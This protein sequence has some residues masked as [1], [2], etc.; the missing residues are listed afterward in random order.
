MMVGYVHGSTTTWQVWDPQHQTV[1]TQSD[2]IFNEARNMYASLPGGPEA[3]TDSLGLI[4]EL[5]HVEVLAAQE[6]GRTATVQKVGRTATVQEVGRTATAQEVGRIAAV[7]EVGRTAA[8]LREVGRTA[9][10]QEVGRTAA[11]L[12]EV[13]CMAAREAD[14]VYVA[15]R[16]AIREVDW[17]VAGGQPRIQAEVAPD[18][19]VGT[20]AA[21]GKQPRERVASLNAVKLVVL[22]TMAALRGGD[23]RPLGQLGLDCPEKKLAWKGPG[24]DREGSQEA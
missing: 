13:G 21:S 4:K 24:Q 9:A 16:T 14:T 15:G 8:A 1:R 11:T 22:Q 2:V 19:V 12:R 3:T 20:K 7:Q 23:S 5:V 10:V 17:I 18:M 6:V